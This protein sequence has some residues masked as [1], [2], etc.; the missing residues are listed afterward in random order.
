MRQL[1]RRGLRDQIDAV[2]E[3]VRADDA[4]QQLSPQFRCELGEAVN[5][6]VWQV[7]ESSGLADAQ[8]DCFGVD[9]RRTIQMGANESTP[10]DP[11]QLFVPAIPPAHLTANRCS[12]TR[13]PSALLSSSRQS[14]SST[15]SRLYVR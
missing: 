3:S 7:D 2:L 5:E 6:F 8:T 13:L 12:C 9:R 1:R 11:R 4:M 15:V 14:P 10:P